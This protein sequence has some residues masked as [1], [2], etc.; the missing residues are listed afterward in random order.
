[1]NWKVV[2]YYTKNTGYEQEVE[3]LI[4]SLKEFGIPYDIEGIESQGSWIANVRYRVN[5]LLRKL[6]E[7]R[8]PIVWIDADGVVVQYP[9]LFDTMNAD[10]ALHYFNGQSLGGTMWF[11]DNDNAREILRSWDKRS[12]AKYKLDQRY[13]QDVLENPKYN[14]YRLPP[15]YTHIFDMMVGDPVILHNQASRRF[16]GQVNARTT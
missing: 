11:N 8:Q 5:F 7:Y 14:V 9:K 4:T 2:S 3:N 13:L 1:M 16:K 15:S 12:D 10:I 6:D